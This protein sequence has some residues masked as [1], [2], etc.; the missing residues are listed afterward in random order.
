MSTSTPVAHEIIPIEYRNITEK[1]FST[2]GI[3]ST[4]ESAETL[5]ADL[6]RMLGIGTEYSEL[7]SSA[8]PERAFKRLLAHFRNNVELLIQKTWVEKADE[9]N[10]EKLLDRVPLFVADLESG[11][12]ERALRI[13][14]RILDELAYLLFGAQSHKGDFIEYTFRID[15][16]IGLFWWYSS[17]ISA[18]IGSTQIRTLRSILLVGVCFL[19]SF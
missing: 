10:K 18:I 16:Q 7:Y 3:G 11:N 19:A 9:A 8:D 14:T 1:L 17:N 15:P 6:A 12:Y 13:F 5:A 4:P 2:A